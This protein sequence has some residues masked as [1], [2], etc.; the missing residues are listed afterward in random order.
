[1]TCP[2]CGGWIDFRDLGQV[3]EHEGELPHPAGDKA[4]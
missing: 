4:Q 2:A 3:Y 1:M